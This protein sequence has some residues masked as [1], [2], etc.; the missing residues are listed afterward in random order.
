MKDKTA[1]LE[2]E[3]LKEIVS[4]QDKTIETLF[5]NLEALNSKV[6][7]FDTRLLLT[8]KGRIVSNFKPNTCNKNKKSK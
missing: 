3:R 8:E 7:S 1:R 6:E 2:L 5:N 4:L